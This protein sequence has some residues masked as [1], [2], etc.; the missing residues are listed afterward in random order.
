MQTFYGKFGYA[1]VPAPAWVYLAVAA[2]WIVLLA[3]TVAVA[4]HSWSRLSTLTQIAL[5][6]AA[7]I[8]ALNLLSSLLNSWQEDFQPQGRYLFPAFSA[9]V[10]LHFGT[11]EVEPRWAL[12][13]RS[14]LWAA[15]IGLGF[16]TLAIFVFF[17][18]RLL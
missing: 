10:V 7:L 1:H 13:L 15:L 2:I 4:F 11:I 16:Y 6:A 8:I 18:Y 12:R 17:D 5:L 14:V 9:L 3:L